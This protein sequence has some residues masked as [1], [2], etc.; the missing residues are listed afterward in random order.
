MVFTYNGQYVNAVTTAKE[1]LSF[2]DE[3]AIGHN[4]PG[5]LMKGYPREAVAP[6]LWDIVPQGAGRRY[7]LR[8]WDI[9][10]DPDSSVDLKLLSERCIAPIDNLRI[11]E[12]AEAFEAQV[13]DTTV[14]S[15][16]QGEISDRD[17]YL[18]AYANQ[19]GV[20]IGGRQGT[21]I[22]ASAI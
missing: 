10:G 14:V 7:L 20:V 3:R 22:V 13:K 9:A 12:A 1:G 17:E 19:L 2:K 15:F 5:H 21:G 18:L 6:I 16:T 11:K 4:V 8:H